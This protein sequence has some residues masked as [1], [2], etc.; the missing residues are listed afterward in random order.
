MTIFTLS[1]DIDNDAFREYSTAE[2][3]H[4]LIGLVAKL[5][6]DPDAT[7][8]TVKDTNGNTVGEWEITDLPPCQDQS[9]AGKPRVS[10][11]ASMTAWFD[12]NDRE[13]S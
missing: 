9:M 5:E 3:Q 7:G 11:V 2:I 8:G 1:C 12:K 10:D 4:I 13:G 6:R